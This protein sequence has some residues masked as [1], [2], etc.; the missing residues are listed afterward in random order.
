MDLFRENLQIDGEKFVNTIPDR[1]SV[2][3]VRVR[4]SAN[5]IRG[6]RNVEKR[7]VMVDHNTVFTASTGIIANYVTVLRFVNTTGIKIDVL[8]EIA[9]GR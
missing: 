7:N 2:K 1:N 5:T 6:K 4:K 3:H 8:K 9:T